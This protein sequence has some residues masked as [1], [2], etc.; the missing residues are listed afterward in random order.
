[1]SQ[2]EFL[3][4]EFNEVHQFAV[5][6]ELSVHADPRASCFYARLALE[7]AVKWLY[8][9]D[10]SLKDPYETTLSAHIHEPTFKNL[11]GDKLVA[12]A[13]V[14]KE[15]GNNAAHER[16]A[17]PFQ[18]SSTSLRELFHFSYWL[19]RSYAKGKKPDA[20]LEFSIDALPRTASVS[21]KNL[22]QLQEIARR[23][24]E[25]VKSREEAEAKRLASED[26]RQKLE[27]ELSA[28]RA[29][30]AKV[31]ASNASLPDTHDYSESETRDAF[32]DILLAEAGWKFSKPGHDTEFRV[33]GMPNAKSEGFVD[34]VL[35]GDD[36]KPLG[37][38]E[39]KRTRK[40]ARVGQQQAKLY[41]DCL[42]TQFGQRPVIFYSNGYEHWI[43]DDRR[44]PPRVVQGF[45][46]KDEL[47]L[48]IRRRTTLKPLNA[49]GI[50]AKIV[51]RFYQTR[52]IRRVA[53]A[54]EKDRLRRALLVMATGTGKTRTVIALADLL[55]RANWARR[56]LFLADRVA[57]VNQAVNAFKTH[58]PASSP[59]NLVTDRDATGRVY[60]ST[61]PTMMGLIDETADGKRRFG[62]G[63]FD[64][65]VID[66]AHRSVYRK[67]GAI[68][69]YFDSL[70]VGLTATPKA[71]VDHNTYGLFDL[72]RGVPTDAYGLEEA[73]KDRFLVPPRAVPLTTDFMDRGINYDN[74]SEPE[75][76]DWDAIEWDETG[77]VPRRVEPPAINKWLFNK[78]TVDK[79]L[80]HLMTNGLKVAEGD[81][82]GKTII[83]AKGQDHARYIVERFDRNYPHLAGSFCRLI[84]SGES[85]AQS[86]IDA[87]SQPDKQPQI[88]VSVDMLDT[89]I[90]VPEVL[91]LVFFKAVRS[92]TKFWQMIGR[93]TRLCHDLFGPGRHKEYFLVFDWCRNFEFFNQDQN[94]IESTSGESL[95]KRLFISR[96][97]LLAELDRVLGVEET[98]TENNEYPIPQTEVLHAG[99]P[100]S[101]SDLEAQNRKL[102]GDMVTVLQSEVRGMSLD[103]FI[104][105]PKRLFVERYATDRAWITL[106][107]NSRS[108]LIQEV[109]GLP[110]SFAD[111][112][113]A[114]KQF[115][116][117]VLKL[118]LALLRSD[119]SIAGLREK[120]TTLVSAL[121]E[122]GNVPM[123]A[124]ELPLILEVQTEEFWRNVTTPEL[125]SVRCRLRG[126][127][128]LIE[129]RKRSIVYSDFAD[130]VRV[131]SPV[132]IPG[133]GEAGLES[134]RMKA[135][136]FLKGHENH[137]AVMKLRRNEP[138][139]PVDLSELERIFAE[140]GAEPSEI[141]KVRSEGGVGL[142]VRSLV[143]LDREAAKRA[144]DSFMLGKP[145]TGNQIEFVNLI[146]DYLT[147]RGT[148]EP[149]LLYE[150]PFTDLD[151]LGVEG[152][153]NQEQAAEVIRLLD[154]VRARAAA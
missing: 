51:E 89:G 107:L 109:A 85:Y 74:L 78:D 146:I 48:A 1:M 29:E 19:V 65:I 68:F 37:L 120:I 145:L 151:P 14:I 142:F 88:A 132:T 49:A 127:I 128:K 112:D 59:V 42:E 96:V 45:L 12:K 152:M 150:S 105:R 75:K 71:E 76:E 62:P 20:T 95:S 134:F 106:G 98:Q 115:D 54:F 133:I 11:L 119:P 130:E 136:Q 22:V 110:S 122:L 27:I 138:L 117:L 46:T 25:T 55:M 44:Y 67:Y 87:F 63:F 43:W 61:Y 113:I 144:F 131:V 5:Q 116:L 101:P 99:E 125:E 137:I 56:V 52:A 108:E 69:D 83:F 7:T 90:D 66:E 84:V 81:R 47:E 3:S 26:D 13:R 82:I 121:E 141:Q 80:E 97:E 139:T 147:E 4:A 35:W 111:D 40:D 104:V 31:K 6:A 23:F 17:V 102:R 10:G 77:A 39:A 2:F 64:L 94:F 50:D 60:V 79:V 33:N 118:Q 16:K 135:R 126:L 148:M 72:Q 30:F 15:L 100:G 123:V 32:I 9:H 114:A 86:L 8:R 21:A 73:V 70:L 103:N 153:F 57:L 129:F 18:K 38:V 93:G 34:Y 58:L 92:K 28:L 149:R 53:E 91:N 140:A 154:D 24:S 41:A 36:G 143:G 124:R